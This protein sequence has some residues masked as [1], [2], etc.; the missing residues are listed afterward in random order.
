MS[1]LNT[2]AIDIGH[3]V[4]YDT[5]AVA[6]RR[7]DELNKLVGEGVISRCRAAGIN[8][9]NCLPENAGSLGDSL[10]Q[11]CDNANKADADFF[12]CI[13]HNCGGGNGAEALI[14]KTG[15][16]AENFGNCILGKLSELGLRNRGVKVRNDLYVINNTSM[17]AVLIECAFVDSEEDMNGYDWNAVADKIFRGICE[18]FQISNGGSSSEETQG[19]SQAVE[20]YEVVSGD[21]LWSIAKRYG[22]TVEDLVRLNSIENAD[23]IYPG[24]KIRTR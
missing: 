20:E 12:L 6:I 22:T 16:I 23:L 17:P 11:R 5:G 9:V 21:T 8:V 7:E 15:G 3:N 1:N 2:L 4:L 18:V 13:H 19:I 10:R 24:Q 14:Y